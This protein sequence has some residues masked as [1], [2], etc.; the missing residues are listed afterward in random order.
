MQPVKLTHE[1]IKKL[2]YGLKSLNEDQRALVE[3]TLGDLS[4]Q[5]GEIWPK[6]LHEALRHLRSEFKISEIDAEDITSALFP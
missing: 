1:R 4:R 3:T 2:V 5:H 6:D